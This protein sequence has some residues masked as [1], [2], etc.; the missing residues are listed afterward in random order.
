[1]RKNDR[2]LVLESNDPTKKD[3][4][5]L[6]KDAVSGKNPLHAS[7]DPNTTLWSLRYERGNIPMPLRNKYT[8]FNSLLRQAQIYFRA[9]NIRIKEIKD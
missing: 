2:I 8:D 1:M 6:D 9:K 3:F 7:M 4:G 5:A